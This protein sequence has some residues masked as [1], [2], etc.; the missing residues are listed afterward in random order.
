MQLSIYHIIFTLCIATS[1]ST[2]LLQKSNGVSYL[3]QMV[4]TRAIEDAAL[5]IPE[6]ST[7]RGRGRGQAPRDN[8]LPSPPP[9]PSVSLEQLLETQ[10]KLMTLLMQ[11]EA[12]CGAGR[13]YIL[14]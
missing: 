14:L 11:N 10:N 2:G 7:S 12:R 8:A 6:G 5:D 13:Q 9:R 4:H 1:Y 3:W